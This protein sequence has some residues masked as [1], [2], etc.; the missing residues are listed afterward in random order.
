ME[1]SLFLSNMP[2]LQAGP[3]SSHLSAWKE[4]CA[5]PA[6]ILSTLAVGHSIRFKRAPPPFNGVMKTSFSSPAQAAVLSA[7]IQELLSKRAIRRVP[8]GEKYAG[9]YAHYFLVPKKSG[10]KRPVLDLSLFNDFVQRM[11]FK[12]LT[13]TQL[14]AAILPGDWCSSIDL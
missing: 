4:L 6:W 2:R 5:P 12:M 10:G 9:F 8:D 1:Y 7:E 11:E 3:L 13:V 14:K